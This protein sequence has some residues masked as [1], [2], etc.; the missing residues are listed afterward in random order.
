MSLITL[1]TTHRLLKKWMRETAFN[2]H[3]DSLILLVAD[4]E[5]LQILFGIP[6]LLFC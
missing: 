4:D 1:G 3:D 2:L 6:S 5:A